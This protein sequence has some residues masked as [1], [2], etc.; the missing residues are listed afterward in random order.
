MSSPIQISD[1]SP[2][3]TINR[4]S[5]LLITRQ[6]VIDTKATVEQVLNSGYVSGNFTPAWNGLTVT[7]SINYGYYSKQYDKVFIAIHASWTGNVPSATSLQITNLPYPAKNQADLIH[8]LQVTRGDGTTIPPS[9]GYTTTTLSAFI[10]GNDS[11]LQIREED[12]IQ[13]IGR[14]ASASIIGQMIITGFYFI[15]PV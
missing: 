12:T 14:Y 6:G 1:L 10:H 8:T 5:D 15:D 11:I 4:N 2:S 3:S 9:V 7:P 13:A